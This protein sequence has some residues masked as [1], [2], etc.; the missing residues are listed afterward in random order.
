[1]ES[2]RARA[3]NRFTG[4]DPYI[5][6]YVA[7]VADAN[8]KADTAERI[9]PEHDRARHRGMRKKN[10]REKQAGGGAYLTAPRLN[11]SNH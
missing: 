3:P 4:K 1:L 2:W 5:H 7:I 6:T 11:G 9:E 10:T 8:L